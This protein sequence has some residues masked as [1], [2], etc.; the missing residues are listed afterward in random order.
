MLLEEKFKKL[1]LDFQEEVACWEVSI[2]KM[3]ELW[4]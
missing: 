4:E 3:L 1:G 2:T